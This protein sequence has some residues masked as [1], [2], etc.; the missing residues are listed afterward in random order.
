VQGVGGQ[1]QGANF[2]F[3]CEWNNQVIGNHSTIHSFDVDIQDQDKG[4]QASK[5]ALRST[6]Y[7][8]KKISVCMPHLQRKIQTNKITDSL[9]QR[10]LLQKTNGQTPTGLAKKESSTRRN[11]VWFMC[12]LWKRIQLKTRKIEQQGLKYL[13]QTLPSDSFIQKS[14]HPQYVYCIDVENNHNFFANNI[15]VHNCQD[16][17]KLEL[18]LVR[19]WAKYQ[20]HIILSGDDDQ[21]IYDFTGASPEAFLSNPIAA[22][23]KRVLNQ[24]WRLPSKIHEFSQRWIKQIT[25]RETKEFLPK[26]VEGN[27]SFINA[28]YRTPNAAIELAARYAQDGKTVMLLASCGYLLNTIKTQLR[29]AGLPFWNPYRQSRG[30]WNPMGSFHNKQAGRISTR[31]RILSFLS[32]SVS[33]QGYWSAEDLARWIELVRVKGILKK[34]AKDKIISL[35]DD[36]QGIIYDEAEFYA[37]IF[38]DFALEHAV[39]RDLKWFKESLLS[40]KRTAVEYPLAVYGKQG[41]AAL[42][43]KPKIILGTVHSVKGGESDATIIFPDLS[44]AAMQD[45]KTN[46][47]STIRTFYVGITRSRES[48]IICQPASDM[49]V[50]FN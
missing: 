47:D 6:G 8:W 43:E 29:S 2:D 23:H 7:F 46:R 35:I 13:R 12:D 38:E 9:W 42:E 19:H 40:A 14:N 25:N 31:E 1:V 26:D 10:F 37:Q 34:G 11:I 15:L 16:F 50:K 4:T 41:R 48:L 18:K 39:A 28:T 3:Q 36:Q 45:F 49:S 44:L 33:G 5:K 24:S 27:V 32:D 22:D 17:N 20:D 30:D 21:T